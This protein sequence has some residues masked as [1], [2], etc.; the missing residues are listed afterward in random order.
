MADSTIPAAIT[1]L[2]ALSTTAMAAFPGVQVFDSDITDDVQKEYLGIAFPDSVDPSANPGVTFTQDWAGIGG[3]RKSEEFDVRCQI[4]TWAGDGTVGDRRARVFAML[5]AFAAAL[6][7]D[8][9]L[10]G[11]ISASGTAK[12]GPGQLIDADTQYGPTA[13]LSFTVEIRNARI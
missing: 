1:A 7:A 5:A 6:R 8:P 10:G 4:G 3:L 13:T 12:V 11:S 2:V 9:G